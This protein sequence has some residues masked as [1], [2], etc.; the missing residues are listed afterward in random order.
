MLKEQKSKAKKLKKWEVDQDYIAYCKR[1]NSAAVFITRD[2]SWLDT[3]GKW[4]DITSIETSSERNDAY[5]QN[6]SGRWYPKF[7]LYDNVIVVK[8]FVAELFP[9][10]TKPDYSGCST[11]EQRKYVTW[12]TATEDI[13]TNRRDGYVPRR[14]HIEVETFSTME[15]NERIEAEEKKWHYRV[16]KL[17]WI[18]K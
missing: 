8:S 9:R 18:S 16:T 14:Y 5:Y 10:L 6:E 17:V 3:T 4:I 12:K 13:L 15:W 7:R 1:G 11:E 2:S